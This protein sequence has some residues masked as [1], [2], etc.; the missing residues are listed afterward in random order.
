MAKVIKARFEF[1]SG[2]S[3]EWAEKN[4][5]LRLDEPG[6]ERDTGKIKFGDGQTRWNDLPY[7][8]SSSGGGPS[9]EELLEHIAS[10]TPHPVY[11]DGPSLALLYENAKV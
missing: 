2:D 8:T 7:F 5:I 6:R 9:D 4:P 10:L 1:K 11:D 3:V